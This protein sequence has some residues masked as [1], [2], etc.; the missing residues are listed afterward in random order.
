VHVEE[1]HGLP[2]YRLSSVG[3]EGEK[4]FVSPAGLATKMFGERAMDFLALPV[5]A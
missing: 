5:A 1:A 2:I 4:A 3:P